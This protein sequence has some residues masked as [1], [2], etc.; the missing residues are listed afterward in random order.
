[1]TEH[2]QPHL[3]ASFVDSGLSDVTYRR[4]T[5]RPVGGLHDQRAGRGKCDCSIGKL[6]LDDG[7]IASAVCCR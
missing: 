2:V 6:S 3:T 5:D 4:H 7:S 1:M